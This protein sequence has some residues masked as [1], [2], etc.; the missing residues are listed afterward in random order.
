MVKLPYVIDNREHTLAGVLDGL[1][2]SAAV[3]ALDVAT[4]YFNV[5][6]FSLLREGR[7]GRPRR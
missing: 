7:A 1:L 2:R 6:G 4:A 3:R 5:G